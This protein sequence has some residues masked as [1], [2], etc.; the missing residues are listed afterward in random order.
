MPWCRDCAR[1]REHRI[2][3]RGQ[4]AAFELTT[5]GQRGNCLAPLRPKEA[6]QQD[7]LRAAKET[8]TK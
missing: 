4:I 2:E 1:H 7:A 5:E 3:L 6:V 8:N